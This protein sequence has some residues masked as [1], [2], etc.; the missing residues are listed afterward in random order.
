MHILIGLIVVAVL[1]AGFALG[2]RLQRGTTPP[3]LPHE[4][5]RRPATD[6]LPGEISE[7]RR[8]V[9]VPHLDGARRLSPYQLWGRTERVTAADDD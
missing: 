6:R 5:P 8:A 4:Q 2:I 9:A 3:P 1:V 7:F